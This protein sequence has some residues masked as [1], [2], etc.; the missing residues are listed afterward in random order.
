LLAKV[1]II[2]FLTLLGA[3]MKQRITV[4]S[5]TKEDAEIHVPQCLLGL[6]NNGRSNHGSETGVHL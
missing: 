5:A 6:P 4:E 3:N 1:G 2:R